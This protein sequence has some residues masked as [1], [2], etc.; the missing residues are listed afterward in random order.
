LDNNKVINLSTFFCLYLARA[1]PSTFIM[2]A[3]QVTMRQHHIGLATI[4]LLSLVRLPWSLKFAW[5]PLIDRHCVTVGDF[6]K[7]LI[8]TE[9]VF[10][11]AIIIVGC[12]DVTKN[13]PIII[14]LVLISTF[15]ASVQNVTSDTLAVNAF[16]RGD[17]SAVTSTKSMGRYV[18]RILGGGF[19][20]MFLHSYGWHVV[21]PL[22]GF[23]ALLLVIPVTL[24]K[25][26]VVREHKHRKRAGFQD[27]LNFFTRR[28]VWPQV[29]FLVLFFAGF[30]GIMVMLKPWMVDM[31]YNM[32]E[33]GL[34]NGVIGTSVAFVM[35]LFAGWWVKRVGVRTARCLVATA[36]LAV[37]VYFLA[38]TFLTPSLPLVLTGI[39]LLRAVEASAAVT[40]YASSMDFV[41]EGR[42]GTDFTVQV[43]I[44]HTSGAL[45]AVVAGGV[46]QWLDYRGLCIIE[47][48]L[49]VVTLVVTYSLSHR[50]K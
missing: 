8:S 17:H 18:G 49:A 16:S 27:L 26:I 15:C 31:G 12:L 25:H 10:A 4:G 20:I 39:I 43:V 7:L 3:L 32:R 11:L 34:Y 50:A 44:V 29:V 28:E 33:I 1:I 37:P 48:A 21:V 38:L 47:L 45:L 22:L 14:A 30:D 35:A 42:E 6:K 5:A 40:L 36:A 2:T 24:N 23:F 19:F 9:L 13:L 46:G 41:R